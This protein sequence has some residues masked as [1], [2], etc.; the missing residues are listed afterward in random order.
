MGTNAT[1]NNPVEGALDVALKEALDLGFAGL[2][3]ALNV[4]VPATALPV[5]KQV[6]DLCLGWIEG[7]IYKS[8]AEDGNYLVLKFETYI[9]KSNYNSA[10]KDLEDAMASGDNLKLMAAR[11]AFAEAASSLIHSDGSVNP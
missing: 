8:I 3:T 9:E 7:V 11:L 1:T 5:V 10:L 2:E 6:I 4:Y